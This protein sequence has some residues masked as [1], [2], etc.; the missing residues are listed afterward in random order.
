M[1]LR[2]GDRFDVAA[3][4]LEE[5]DP[6]LHF[7]IG[8]IW[9]HRDRLG[10]EK[11]VEK[12]LELTVYRYLRSEGWRAVDARAASLHDFIPVTVP[13]SYQVL[14]FGRF[15]DVRV[16]KVMVAPDYIG[17]R[18]GRGVMLFEFEDKIFERLRREEKLGRRAARER[19]RREA[20]VNR[21]TVAEM[22]G[23]LV[24]VR[25]RKFM[26]MVTVPTV[27][28]FVASE[29][30]HRVIDAEFGPTGRRAP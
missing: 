12:A 10:L 28:P 8:N 15:F 23:A 22:R 4:L 19:A 13:G 21:R 9:D 16:H 14:R 2:T 6:E 26:A 30:V 29:L 3:T 7:N 18:L 20:E 17:R 11:A 27:D 1:K 25:D 5:L 24:T